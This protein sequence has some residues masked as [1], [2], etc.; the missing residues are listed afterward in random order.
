VRKRMLVDKDGQPSKWRPKAL[1]GFELRWDDKRDQWCWV[2]E[3]D[4]DGKKDKVVVWEWMPH[5]G[6]CREHTEEFPLMAEEDLQLLRN[7]EVC[8]RFQMVPHGWSKGWLLLA[9]PGLAAVAATVGFDA[10]I[11]SQVVDRARVFL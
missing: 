4:V 11:L 1:A 8:K 10:R 3:V 7:Q 9:L 2:K 5:P 6:A